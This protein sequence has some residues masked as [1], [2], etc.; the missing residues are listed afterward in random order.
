MR[1]MPAIQQQKYIAIDA[2]VDRVLLEVERRQLV[3]IGTA[4]LKTRRRLI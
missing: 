2:T 4:D 1:Q 3:R